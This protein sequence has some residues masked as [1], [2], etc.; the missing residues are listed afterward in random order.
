MMG[1]EEKYSQRWNGKEGERDGRQEE[2][3]QSIH[4]LTV[5]DLIFDLSDELQSDV[6][7]CLDR[8]RCDIEALDLGL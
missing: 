3:G 5:I 6:L 4:P 2:G 1:N 8:P 7:S